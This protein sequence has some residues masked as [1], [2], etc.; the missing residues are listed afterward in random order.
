MTHA[1]GSPGIGVDG[2]L[3]VVTDRAQAAVTG[4]GLIDVVAAAADGGAPVV[5]LR[6]KDLPRGERA[7]LAAALVSVLAGSGTALLV[8]TDARLAEE[9]GAVGVHLAAADDAWE[10]V[11]EAGRWLL[12]GRSCHGIPELQAAR[13]AGLDYAT[14]SPVWA[15]ASKPGYGPGLGLGGLAAGVAAVPG[16]PVYALGGVEPGRAADCLSAGAAGVAVMG[17]IMRADDPAKVVRSL[18]EELS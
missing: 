4:Q 1:A 16:L 7:R 5:L 6:E 8:A 3:I 2:R 18:L 17:A 13:S 14:L 15:T 10:A 9:V 11:A 12:V